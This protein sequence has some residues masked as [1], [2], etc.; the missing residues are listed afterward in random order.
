MYDEINTSRAEAGLPALSAAE[1]EAEGVNGDL[2][3]AIQD[4]NALGHGRANRARDRRPAAGS[5]RCRRGQRE[6]RHRRRS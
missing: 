3:Q 5:E 4:Y 1:M 2:A 6:R